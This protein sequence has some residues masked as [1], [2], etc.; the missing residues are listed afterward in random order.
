MNPPA[1]GKEQGGINMR[2]QFTMLALF[3]LTAGMTTG[4]A[5][6]LKQGLDEHA[7][8]L[9]AMQT[10]LDQLAEQSG[11]QTQEMDAIRRDVAQ[12]GLKITQA[13]EQVGVL[14]N[15]TENLNT[16]IQLLS[17]DVTRLKREA[18][19]QP[20]TTGTL[21]FTEGP[22][23]VA[24]GNVLAI[25]NSGLR[26]YHAE[27]PTDWRN[28]IAEFARVLEMAPTSDLADNAEYWSGECYYKLEEYPQALAAF[29]RVFDHQGSNKYEDA[30]LKIGMTYREMGRRDEA[31]AALQ[32]LLRKYPTSQYA[33]V[34]RRI[35]A[36]IG[37]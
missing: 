15:K 18:E 35:L 30:Q 11:Q 27:S 17:D 23:G 29:Q 2:R 13:E 3:V 37:G 20:A 26:L 31:I 1:G 4:C 21:R 33:E 6:G 34:A 24:A 16:R 8:T 22:P 5:A 25:Y 7:A 19:T 9:E 32:E 28:A 12:M 10:R 36:E 14:N